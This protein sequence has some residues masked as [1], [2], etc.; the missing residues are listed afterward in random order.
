MKDEMPASLTV[1]AGQ[2]ILEHLGVN[3]DRGN[4]DRVKLLRFFVNY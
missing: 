2:D 3:T 4:T 1:D